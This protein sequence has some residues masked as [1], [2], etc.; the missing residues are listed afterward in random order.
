M[1]KRN[2]SQEKRRYL[3]AFL[4][5]NRSEKASNKL[6]NV[7]GRGIQSPK[8]STKNKVHNASYF[9]LAKCNLIQM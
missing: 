6:D 1:L 5:Y 2:F 3:G 8:Q 9:Q 4:Y 7:Q